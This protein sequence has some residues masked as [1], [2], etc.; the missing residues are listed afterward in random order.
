MSERVKEVIRELNLNKMGKRKKHFEGEITANQHV[1]LYELNAVQAALHED[2]VDG[3]AESDRPE[4]MSQFWQQAAA[5]SENLAKTDPKRCFE[6]ALDLCLPSPN[7]DPQSSAWIQGDAPPIFAKPELRSLLLDYLDHGPRAQELITCLNNSL[8]FD[9]STINT[10]KELFAS[11]QAFFATATMF[12]GARLKNTDN[13]AA[14]SLHRHAL[15]KLFNRD[16]VEKFL[17][18]SQA[19]DA[20]LI[21]LLRPYSPYIP[22]VTPSVAP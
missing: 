9:F 22:D 17:P 8:D 18:Y 12:L 6:L 2:P 10:D 1:V 11:P 7:A 15:S 19:D 16:V 21:D 13:P 5:F 4:I 14:E 3:V 20:W